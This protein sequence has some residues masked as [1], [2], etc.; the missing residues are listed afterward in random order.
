MTSR[1][2]AHRLRWGSALGGII[3]VGSVVACAVDAPSGDPSGAESIGDAIYSDDANAVQNSAANSQYD[4][5]TQHNDNARAGAAVHESTLT[6]SALKG[7]TF[8]PL[9][10]V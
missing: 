6:P 2:R 9:G 7:G 8:G 3:A 10:S 1:M 5:L 4:V